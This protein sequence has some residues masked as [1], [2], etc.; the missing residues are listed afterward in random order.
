MKLHELD[1][2]FIRRLEN[3]GRFACGTWGGGTSPTYEVCRLL[4]IRAGKEIVDRTG[5]SQGPRAEVD[6]EDAQ[7]LEWCMTVRGG[8]LLPWERALIVSH[9]AYRKDPRTVARAMK[10]G[11]GTWEHL[12][13][14]AI[15]KLKATVEHMEACSAWRTV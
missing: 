13:C 6:T 10:V 5:N 4:A 3:W 1:Q 12:L 2:G 15:L 11:R 9:F 8:S 14:T 7:L